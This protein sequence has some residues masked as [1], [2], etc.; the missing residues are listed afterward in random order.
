MDSI[1][2][3]T[4]LNNALNGEIVTHPVYLVYDWFVINRKIDWQSLFDLG[5]GRINHASLLEIDRPNLK[6]VETVSDNDSHKRTDVRWITDIGELHECSVDGWKCEH[7]IKTSGDYKI[8]QRALEDV[9]FIP[10]DKYFDESEQALG[11][12]GITIGQLGQFNDLGYLRTPFQVVQIDFVGLEQFSLD[13]ATELPELME[14]LEMMDEQLLEAFRRVTCTKAI[15]VKLWE[16]LSIETMGP[17]FFRRY[18]VPLYNKITKILEDT[19]KKLQVHYDG[20]LHLVADDILRLGFDGIDSLTPPPEGD[21]SI[22]E[23]R[24]LWPEKFLWMH[25]SLSWDIL[26]DA[27][28]AH[29][30]KQ[31]AHDAGTRYC[32]Q[33]SEEVPPNWKRTIPLILKTL[34]EYSK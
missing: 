8:M 2:I 16:N 22:A 18:L 11:E 13:I 26:P 30:V 5:L 9:R 7:L 31:M 19:G 25:P 24:R 21:I 6:I 27:E 29:K 17:D 28:I 32:F 15:Q 14:L 23:A 10:T 12:S 33:L 34:N 4:Q 1:S 3:R 20:K